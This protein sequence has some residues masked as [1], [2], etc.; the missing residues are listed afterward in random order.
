MPFH[1]LWTTVKSTNAVVL[2]LGP[3]AVKTA[4]NLLC[5]RYEHNRYIPVD[6]WPPYHPKHYTPLAIVHHEGRCTE[7]EVTAFAQGLT[8]CG[9]IAAN[10]QPSNI[11]NDTIKTVKELCA[12]LENAAS[13]PYSILIEGA[14]GIGKTILCKEIAL[15]W[16]RK[17]IL[18]SKSLLFLLFMREPLVECIRDVKSLVQYFCQGDD[19][20][21]NV[22]DWLVK[23]DGENLVIVIDGYD[24]ASK[25]SKRSFI[26]NGIIDRNCLSKCGLIITSR[27]AASLGLHPKVNCRA[28]VLGFTEDNRL[29]FISS[30]LEGQD[31]KVEGLQSFLKL[32]PM[33]NALCYIPL[34]MRI[35][36]CLTQDGIDALPKSKTKLYYSFIIMTIGHF[37][38]KSANETVVINSLDELPN[39]HDQA[40][41]QLAQFAFHALEKEKLVFSLAELRAACPNLTPT[42]WYGLG[43]LKQVQFFNPRNGKHYES[44]H[45]LHYSVQEYMAAQ[46]VKSLPSSQLSQKLSKTFYKPHYF[47]MWIMYVGITGGTDPHFK[48]FLSTNL[49]ARRLLGSSRQ[50]NDTSIKKINCLYLLHCLAESANEI[51]LSVENIFQEQVIDLSNQNLLPDDVLTVAMAL[52]KS[53][54]NELKEI[55]LSNCNI[56]EKSCDMLCQILSLHE[57]A[58]TVNRINVSGNWFP[59][60]SLTQLCEHFAAWNCGE[61]VTSIDSLIYDSATIDKI[62]WFMSKLNREIQK[63]SE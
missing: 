62:Y 26:N 21:T 48:T 39:P 60:E 27:P 36:L 58:L 1:M 52:V 63:N 11:Y 19:L 17:D 4:A 10:S 32:N 9:S 57:V 23:N 16:S 44:F 50:S 46:Y 45:F 43:L 34:N 8:M 35:L 18:K 6:D 14:P 13:D 38:S 42:G 31:D 41:R 2:I 55:N 33:I 15:Q 28:E 3:E 53:S 51:F 24:E 59:R 40:I 5:N 37:L 29:N 20:T 12:P 61:I 56:N 22:T 49:T 54:G 47:N 7:A 30:A 25:N